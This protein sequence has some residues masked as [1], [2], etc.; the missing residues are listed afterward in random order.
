MD[1]LLKVF[2]GCNMKYVSFEIKEKVFYLEL[3]RP[4][5]RNAFHP[6]FISELTEVFETKISKDIVCVVLSAKGKSFCA[7]ADLDYMKSMV[8]FSFEENIKDAS[9]LFHMFEAIYKCPAPTVVKV[10]GHVMGG[11][12]GVV[13]A[14]DIVACENSTILSFSEVHLGLVASVICPFVLRK[15]K[16]SHVRKWMLTGK[17]FSAKE[18]LDSQL[19]H[20]VGSSEKVGEYVKNEIRNFKKLSREAIR[21][22]K[23]LILDFESLTPNLKKRCVELIAQ[24]RKSDEAQKLMEAFLKRT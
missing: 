13:S 17:R 22:T 16:S 19:V 3:S 12:L 6:E 24:R 2:L 15:L 11:G 4:E 5:K 21:E 23:K 10:Y 14:C 18:A 7:G 1:A 9:N 8:D 20:F